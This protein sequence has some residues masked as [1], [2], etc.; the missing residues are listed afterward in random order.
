MPDKA[1][2]V[3][4]ATTNDKHYP[5]MVLNSLR[6]LRK[7]NSDIPVVCVI[8]GNLD[9]AAAAQFEQMGAT[10]FLEQENGKEER[11]FL[12]W[13]ALGKIESES[14][15]F[16]DADTIIFDDLSKI[17]N[18][19]KKKLFYAR[20][21]ALTDHNQGGGGSFARDTAFNSRLNGANKE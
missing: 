14:V 13:S 21:E 6:T 10:L 3:L 20:K 12:K 16:L 11:F 7:H 19:Y 5:R 18:R 9:A 2:T 17:F 8:Y 15:L 1:R 4:Y